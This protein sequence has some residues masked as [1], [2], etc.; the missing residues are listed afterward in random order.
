MNGAPGGAAGRN[1]TAAGEGG[2]RSAEGVP[3]QAGTPEADVPGAGSR[4]CGPLQAGDP[5]TGPPE[6]GA[7]DAGVEEAASNPSGPGRGLRAALEAVLAETDAPL[8][9][10]G[11]ALFPAGA[12]I[13]HAVL[14]R[15]M[16]DALEA[17]RA[18]RDADPFSNPIHLLALRLSRRIDAGEVSFSD[19]EQ[20]IQRLTTDAFLAGAERLAARI[21]ETDPAANARIVRALIV[22][23][24]RDP[25]SG[26][27]VP[28]ETFRAAVERA[29][30][31]IVFTAHPTFAL[32]ERLVRIQAQLATGH[33]D[34]GRRLSAADRATLIR[35][36]LAAEHRPEPVI[37]L[38]TEHAFS[39]TAIAGARDALIRV[40]EIVFE[41]ARE[42]W[43]ER[44]LEL[45]PRLLTIASW[46]GYDLD[47]R[48]DIGWSETFH[49]RLIVQRRQLVHY[50]D[51][52]VGLNGAAGGAPDAEAL[53][54][55]LELLES[56]LDLAIRTVEEEIAVFGRPQPD[57]AH[58]A[59]HVS[60]IARRMY[61]D[62][63]RRLTRAEPLIELVERAIARAAGLAGDTAAATLGRLAVLRAE[64]ANFGLGMAHTHV[65]LNATQLHNAIRREIG[66]E[67]APDDPSHR[68]SYIAAVNA[69]LDAVEPV[70]INFGS[71]LNE[72]ASAKRL[73]MVVAQM[74]K[75]VDATT[76]V[77]FL[78]AECETSFTLL[79][80][81]Y[82]AKLLGVAD[83]VEI[84]PLFETRKALERGPRVIDELLENPH[85]RAYVEKIGRLCVQTGYSDTGRNLGQTVAGASV[86]RMRMRIGEVFARHD[87]RGVELLIFDTHGESI[88]R[89]AHPASFGDRLRYVSPPESRRRFARDGTVFKQETSFQGG[90][91]YVWFFTPAAAFASVTRILEFA[92]TPPDEAGD[93]FYEEADYIAEFFTTIQFFYDAVMHDPD[94]AALLGAFGTNMLYPIG[95]RSLRR[96]HEPGTTADL[97]HPGQLRAIPHNATLQQ[98][99]Y[100]ANTLAGAGRAIRKNPAAFRAMYD[101]S[102]RF[103]RMFGMITWALAFSDTDV[104]KAYV[105]TLDPGAWLLRMGRPRIE[106]GRFDELRTISGFIEGHA[107]H[108]RLSSILRKLERDLFDMLHTLAGD[109]G[110]EVDVP[111]AMTEDLRLLHVIRI[112]LIQRIFMLATHIPEF[113]LRYELSPEELRAHILRLDIGE[114]LEALRAIFPQ[115]DSARRPEDF[116]E[117]AT[118]ETDTGQSYAHEHARIFRPMGRLYD[119]VRRTGTGVNHIIGTVG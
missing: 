16:R 90:D 48:A 3:R 82:F 23:L 44:W 116:G 38:G 52:V 92:L 63:E 42:I 113:S 2:G 35:R 54:H 87:L 59:G 67:A 28:F 53:R 8:A 112:T 109:V 46:V 88:G 105:D 61:A 85:Y 84:S 75:Y 100:L 111:A 102:P 55:I 118:Y 107:P 7:P 58:R 60:R 72:G 26:A 10:E 11:A 91:G 97:A 103:R 108:D 45:R 6:T 76:P 31:G 95:S 93:P 101:A 73:M 20:L 19:V 98:L 47:G 39:L 69:L 99:G 17:L 64:L 33:D 78:I 43:P 70:T 68:R 27:T 24:T 9:P 77:R 22:D 106:G 66:M 104:L 89:G 1:A 21:G 50:R 71:L 49:R 56:R 115:D 36:A 74:L 34:R 83:R 57:S 5:D 4:E 18:A 37:D 12:G 117:P 119:L 13:G 29:P 86:E 40:Y 94:Y 79:T 96:Q 114:A 25:E 81:L 110:L 80:A 65:R 32:S 30:F 51:T 62:R 41:V 15:E 14:D